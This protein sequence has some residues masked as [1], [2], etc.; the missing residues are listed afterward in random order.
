MRWMVV[1]VLVPL[2]LLCLTSLVPC[3]EWYFLTNSSVC[4]WSVGSHVSSAAE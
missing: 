2:V 4:T 1:L 3:F